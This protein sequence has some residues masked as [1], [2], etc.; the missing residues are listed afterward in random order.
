MAGTL[1]ATVP[2]S[3]VLVICIRCWLL[4]FLYYEENFEGPGPKL[5]AKFW[6]SLCG[7]CY[8]NYMSTVTKIKSYSDNNSATE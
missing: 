3:V 2:V 4:L 8:H 1:S 7:K 6:Q 5:T